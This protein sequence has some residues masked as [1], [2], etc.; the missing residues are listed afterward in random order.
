MTGSMINVQINEQNRSVPDG[1][2][3]GSLRD[4]ER[5]G[6]DVLVVNG[7]PCGPDTEVK[8]GDQV[9]F[10]RRGE[11][12]KEEELESLM[13]ARHTPGVHSR[14]KGSAVGVAGLG[15]LGSNVAVALVRM[16]IGTL[17]LADFDLV[18][19]SNLN[20]QQYS[21]EHIG[22]PKTDAMTQILLDINPYTRVITHDVSLDRN[23][24]PQI[25]QNV[26]VIVE[27]LDRAEAKAMFIQT[28]LE[29]LPET[30]IIG[31]S[32]LAG[33]GDSN[34]IQSIR[35]GEKI[36][37]VG[38]LVTP[39]EPGRGLMAPRVGIAAHHQANLVVSLLMDSE[40]AAL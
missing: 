32:G 13:V 10:I 34:N 22:M 8:E 39:A 27:C 29:L 16:G 26:D 1:L 6:A 11:T 17:I 38:D 35:L 40:K 37:M 28:V 30:Y 20:R 12:P 3:V 25:F 18:E 19:P 9:V 36:F 7:F 24:I 2:T 14:M 5:P 21:I 4:Q 33:Y 15:G 23:N 31:A